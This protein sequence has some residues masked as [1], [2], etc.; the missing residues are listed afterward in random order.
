MAYN[1]IPLALAFDD[2][3]GNASGLVEFTL[4][5]TSTLRDFCSGVTPEEGQALV[6]S[7]NGCYA[8]STIPAGGGGGGDPSPV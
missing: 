2:N 8:P 7:S 3:T 1:R 6:F 5:S 4:S